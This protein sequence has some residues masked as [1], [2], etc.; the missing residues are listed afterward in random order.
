MGIMPGTIMT[1]Q[2]N[3][4]VSSGGT[5]N[6]QG[7]LIL[8]KDLI[9]QNPSP[10]SLGSGTIEMSGTTAQNISGQNIIQ[11]L[12]V[13]NSTGVILAGNTQVNGTLTLTNGVVS[14]GS[15][16]LT[17]GT[18]ANVSGTFS[19]TKMVA[20]DGTGQMRKEFSSAGS[21]TFPVGDVTIT[22][23]Y[24]PVTLNFTSGTFASGAYAGVNL[25][26]DKYPSAEIVNNYLTRYWNVSQN[27][28]T[29]FSCNATYNY[30][31]LDVFGTESKLFCVK[32]N[33][34]P[35]AGYDAANTVTHQLMASGLNSFSSYTGVGVH[36]TNLSVFLEGL[37][38]GGG[39][40]VKAQDEFGDHFPG[41]TAD[42]VTVELHDAANYSNLIYSSGLV[43]VSTTGGAYLTA[44]PPLYS[45]SY[46]MTIKHRNSIETTTAAP[47]SFAGSLITYNYSTA[48]SQAYA[49][50][51]KDMGDGYFALYTGDVNQ[52][53]IVD[54]GDMNPVD[55]DATYTIFVG[56]SPTDING[57]GL[58]DASDMNFVDNNS[59]AIVMAYLP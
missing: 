13:N 37:Y 25:T 21:F 46:Y 34:S 8:K 6:N 33:P 59:T 52:D 5:L 36:K 53:G 43:D 57:D 12:V 47:V 40:M 14:L 30:P 31:A 28:I 41:N 16:N 35:W 26:D 27:N 4:S 55:N 29:N 50:N 58:V 15:N 44:V 7:T 45:G 39:T 38:A 20:A 32:V 22:A 48:A 10:N 42:Q 54:G 51:M 23:D 49:D 17:L 18:S 1:T 9:N 11:N 19:S 56:Y 3:V 2:N 24:S